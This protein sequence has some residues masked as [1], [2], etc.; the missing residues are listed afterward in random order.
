[1]IQLYLNEQ[2]ADISK[3]EVI[4]LTYQLNNIA[5]LSTRNGNFSN[6]ITLPLSKTN[7][8]IIENTQSVPS[9][10]TTPYKILNCRVFQNGIE[11][12][13]KGLAV[14]QQINTYDFEIN[15]FSGLSNFFQLIEGLSIQDLNLSDLDHTYDAATIY[16]NRDNDYTSGFCYPVIDYGLLPDTGTEVQALQLYPSVFFETI[17]QAI[18]NEQNYTLKGDILSNEKFLRVISAFSNEEFKNGQRFIDENGLSGQQTTPQTI[19]TGLTAVDIDFYSNTFTGTV[20]TGFRIDLNITS[21]TLPTN[22]V[23]ELI[24]EKNG[25]FSESLG[26][27]TTFEGNYSFSLP[28]RT[29]VATDVINFAFRNNPAIVGSG[30]Y[31]FS[32]TFQEGEVQPENIDLSIIDGTIVN[33]EA[34]LP[35]MTQEEWLISCFN[36]FGII[37][38]SDNE[39]R[40]LTL[41]TFQDVYNNKSIGLDWSNKIDKRAFEKETKFRTYAQNN[42]LKY[43]EDE[44]VNVS[45]DGVL[46]VNDQTLEQTTD[47][48]ELEYSA[49][50]TANYFTY[51]FQVSSIPILTD[52]AGTIAITEKVEPR[53]LILE[54]SETANSLQWFQD[55][56]SI[57]TSNEYKIGRFTPI[58]FTNLKNEFYNFLE[59]RIL[60]KAQLLTFN[61][62]LTET[63]IKNLDLAV[64]VYVEWLGGWFYINRINEFTGSE[65]LTECD[66]IQ[67]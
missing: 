62:K 40:T 61:V 28:Q 11:V 31:D 42:N 23:I 21:I 1:M 7:K 56:A 59:N 9:E 29:Y 50:D 66:I 38:I 24:L 19:N 17:L 5:E 34:T 2:L 10:G 52:D 54:D 32:I 13:R 67:I 46:K 18:A 45:G 16:A 64:P 49:S 53:V 12:I 25:V 6:R 36:Q 3:G 15:I 43:K 14:I 44:I 58:N 22:G 48:I 26:F 37:P 20:V 41:L 39:E 27:I 65:Q 33:L 63:D 55:V 57:G 8:S 51:Q 30:S 4:A 60:E 47:L 35:E